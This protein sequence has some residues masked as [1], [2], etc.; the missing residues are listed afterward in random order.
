[1]AVTVRQVSNIM[2]A[3]GRGRTQTRDGPEVIVTSSKTDGIDDTYHP[4]T[5]SKAVTAASPYAQP[6]IQGRAIKPTLLLCIKFSGAYQQKQFFTTT[7]R[8]CE[9]MQ[10]L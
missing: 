9:C 5:T 3:Y 10:E 6:V 1:M 2:A 4:Q 7:F 8:H